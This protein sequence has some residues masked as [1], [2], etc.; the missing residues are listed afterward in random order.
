MDP[1]TA[2]LMSAAGAV[3][4]PVY[5]DDVFSTYLYDGNGTS[6]TINNGIDVS[7]EGGLVWIKNREAN[8]SD[9]IFTD[10]ERG[11]N[12]VLESNRARVAQS[13]TDMITS[14]NSNG[15]AVADNGNVNENNDGHCSWTFRKA[16]GFFDVVT[17]TGN[18]SHRDISH[19]LGSEPGSIWIKR[20]DGDESWI[21]YHRSLDQ[22]GGSGGTAHMAG[23]ELESTGAQYGGTLRWSA[24]GGGEDHTATTFH[25][26]GHSAING[27][28]MTYVAYIFA[29]DDQSFGTDEDESIIKCGSYT[30]TGAAGNQITLGFEPQWLIVKNTS[31]N[32]NWEMFD[33]MR[34]VVT[35]GIAS[36]LFPNTNGTE[37]NSFNLFN[38]NATGFETES[39]LDETNANGDNYVYIAIRRPHKPPSA[40]T[41]VFDVQTHTSDVNGVLSSSTIT[42]DAVI[43][44]ARDSSSYNNMFLTRSLGK[45]LT[46]NNNSA[47]SSASQWAYDEQTGIRHTDWFGAQNI[48]DYTYKRAP[49]FFDVVTYAGNSASGRTVLH[50]LG[51]VPELMIIKSRDGSRAWRVY[52]ANTGASGSLRLNSDAAKDSNSAYWSTPTADNIILGTDNDTNSSSYDYIAYL[53]ATLSGISKVGSYTGTGSAQ[54][55]DCGFTNGAR[56]ILIKRTD[57]SGHW[58][59]FDT[60]RGIVSGNDPMLFLN[61]TAA[62]VNFD[63]VDPL[64]SGFAIAN[65]DQN[66]INASGGTYIFL[67]IA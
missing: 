22:G 43:S 34:G 30:G 26:S 61:L 4:D 32:Q 45:Y 25:V 39:T 8:A 7:G 59:V 46:T 44:M 67:A 48:V 49:G 57:S 31:S 58:I 47:A 28:G 3:A 60:A 15:F 16:P 1:V 40:G 66:D 63:R 20:T 14:F 11:T 42:A 17:Y 50:N 37:R 56:F 10:T 13:K 12:T 23:L 19:S 33:N 38:F 52:D 29:H 51:V 55:I 5:V 35:G 24:S 2:K 41:E 6:Q 54:N 64:S 53:F 18:G 9:H 36:E 21:V 27:S 62:E 65:T